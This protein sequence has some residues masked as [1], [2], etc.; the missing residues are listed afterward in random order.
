MKL[1]PLSLMFA[2]TIVGCGK[3]IVDKKPQRPNNVTK[4]NHSLNPIALTSDRNEKAACSVTAYDD[5]MRNI[6]LSLFLHDKQTTEERFFAGL[7][8]GLF[9]RDVGAKI[10]TE[11]HKGEDSETY[12]IVTDGTLTSQDKTYNTKPS[13]VTVCPDEG[14]YSRGSVESAALNANYFISKTN[15]KVSQLLPDVKIS[16]ISI[17]I[18]PMLLEKAD[19]IVDGKVVYHQEAYQTDN[20]YYMPGGNSIT[21]LPHSEEMKKQGF[22]MNFWEVPM[23]GSHEY[24]HHIFE[25]LYPDVMPATGLKNC[26]GNFG[27]QLQAGNEPEAREVTNDDVLGALNEGFADLVAYYSLDN[28]ERGLWGVPCLQV[29]RDV[30]SDSFANVITKKVFSEKALSD[31][32]AKTEIEAPLNCGIPNFQDTHIIGAIFANGVD[33]IMSVSTDSKDKRLLITLKW[34][35]AMKEKRPSLIALQPKEFLKGSFKLFI[36]TVAANTDGKTDKQECDIA[37]EIYPGIDAEIPACAPA[38]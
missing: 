34:L 19:V 16:P 37:K 22:S 4:T 31:F 32:F 17:E 28:S 12:Y 24:G 21:F 38:M 9:V 6:S 30:G 33:R 13:V 29:S 15:R 3:K 35:Q 14:K 2:L 26:F 18:A 25:T 36:A 7:I 5:S 23:V 1:L 20:A 27:L 11:T 10:I 8:E